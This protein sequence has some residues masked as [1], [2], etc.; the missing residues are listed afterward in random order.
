MNPLDL[1][2]ALPLAGFLLLLFLPKD[3][4]DVIRIVALAVSLIV[5]VLSLTLISPVLASP[6]SYSF[7]TDK[8]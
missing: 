3:K 6:A 7:V 4:P 1:V 8:P 2:I 5:F